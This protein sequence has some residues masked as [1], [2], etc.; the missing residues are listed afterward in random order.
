M[1]SELVL[2]TAQFGSNYGLCNRFGKPDFQHV[3]AILDVAKAAGVETLD[4]AVSYGSADKVLGEAD[5][6]GYF[7]I[8][9]KL[10]AL[11]P[12]VK[13]VK[14]WVE[15]QIHASLSRMS[16]Q[17]MHGLLVHNVS[18]V[19]G[20]NGLEILGAMNSLKSCGLIEKIGISV[21]GP[22]D[23][24]CLIDSVELDLVQAPV[25]VFDRSLEV[26]GYLDLLERRGIEVH[27]RSVFLQ[28]ILLAN[29]EALPKF[30]DR[31]SE[32]LKSWHQYLKACNTS[33]VAA[34]L[35]YPASL[36]GVSKIVVGV[37]S[38]MQLREII[39]NFPTNRVMRPLPDW[40]STGADMARLIDPR[41]WSDP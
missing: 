20:S 9:S 18:D 31:W 13:D 4:T 35:S 1:S 2:G 15:R 39:A 5:L 11:P 33:A 28:G 36:A 25:N 38:V 32:S 3:C 41:R 24:D 16:R 21:Y 19:R 6:D 30:F 14:G 22:N 29:Q 10:P 23:L 7:Q 26:S 17:S 12:R 27:A 8:V 37:E 40:S 34:C